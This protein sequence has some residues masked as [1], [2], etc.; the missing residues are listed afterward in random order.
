[1]RHALLLLLL[2]GCGGLAWNT[3]VADYWEVRQAMLES[4][5]PGQTTKSRFVA[6]WGAPTQKIR[7]GAQIS[8]VYRNMQNPE[9]YYASQ[10]GDSTRFVVVVFQ[11]GV[12]I[13]AYSSETQGC[14][15][16]FP[17]RPPGPG[18]DNP[19][20]IKPV[21]CGVSK[22]QAGSSPEMQSVP[23]DRYIPRKDIK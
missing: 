1:M 17:P 15:A 8:Y 12:A 9:G 10:F 2:A 23:A 18:F 21:N 16:T 19:S 3:E 14:R 5:Q 22:T 11:Y 20:T 13:D 4:V 6:Q 7:E